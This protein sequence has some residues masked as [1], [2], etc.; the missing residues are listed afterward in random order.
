MSG[1]F[2]WK[3][4]TLEIFA[5]LLPHMRVREQGLCDRGWCPFIYNVYVC[6]YV[7]MYVCVCMCICD[8][9]KSLNGN[10]AV[11]SPFQTRQIYRLVLPL[12]ASEMLPL[13]G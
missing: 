8:P 2:R 3:T 7:C 12:C 10:L 1:N 13:V 5:V 6:M 11:D 4:I 9:P